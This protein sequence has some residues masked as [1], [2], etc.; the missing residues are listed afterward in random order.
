[1]IDSTLLAAIREF[2]SE[3]E[4][5][6]AYQNIFTAYYSRLTEVTVIIGKTTEGDSANAQVVINRDDY[7][8]WMDTLRARLDEIDADGVPAALPTEHVS[9]F[10]RIL[11]T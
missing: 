10:R 2:W 8:E 9:H 7:R 4:T 1:M 6:T 3:E 5:R 11:S